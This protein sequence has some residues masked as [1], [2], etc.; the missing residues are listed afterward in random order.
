MGLLSD[1][2]GTA[3]G[4]ASEAGVEKVAGTTPI[5]GDEGGGGEPRA[6]T[7][8]ARRRS[9]T[10]MLGRAAGAGL[11]EDALPEDGATTAGMGREAAAPAPRAA[12]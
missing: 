3:D 10:V 9:A 12:G 8:A 4:A 2:G 1:P 6:G 11:A 5:P 7:D